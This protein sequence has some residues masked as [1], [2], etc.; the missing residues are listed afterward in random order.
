MKVLVLGV[1]GMLGHKMYQILSNDFDVYA[2]CRWYKAEWES[3]LPKHRLIPGVQVEVFDNLLKAF[4]QVQ[5][6]VVIN[7][8][9]VI[10]Q[11]DASKD[12]ILS[13]SINSL[14]PHQLALLCQ[15]GGAR[16]FHFSTDCIFSGKKGSYTEEDLPD[17]EDLYGKT[18]YLGEVWR[19]GCVTIRSSIIGR[20]LSS[21]RGLVEWL[22]SQNGTS[23]NGFS[24]AIY[25]GITTNVMTKVVKDLILNHTELSGVWQVASK[26]ISKYDL[27]SLINERMSLN[28]DIKKDVQFHCDRSLSGQRFTGRTGFIA[29]P[30]E[31]M[32]D[33]MARD[34]KCYNYKD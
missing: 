26:P 9:G 12:P 25:T 17:A 23:V 3:I 15:S 13:I 19:N 5:P 2:S 6:D 4:A 33:E 18:K 8:I 22:I 32:I 34:R 16:L 21:S 10:K 28:I 1:Y 7:C 11:L 14:F 30:W 29:P 31:E 27:L 24:K 20:E